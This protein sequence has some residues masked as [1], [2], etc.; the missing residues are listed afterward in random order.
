MDEIRKVLYTGVYRG[1]TFD[2]QTWSGTPLSV[3]WNK[4]KWR[5]LPG[6]VVEIKDCDGNTQTFMKGLF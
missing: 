6:D 1:H 2:I 3:V 4:E 5:F